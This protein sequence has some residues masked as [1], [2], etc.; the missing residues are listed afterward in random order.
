L[1]FERARIDPASASYSVNRLEKAPDIHVPRV[2]PSVEMSRPAKMNRLSGMPLYEYKCQ[3]CG[4]TFEVLQKFSDPALRVHEKCGGHVE[5]LI[6]TAAL[7]FKGS[8]WY[9]TDYASS[10]GKNQPS[11]DS[12][13][14][15]K[16]ENSSSGHSTP[17]TETKASPT[18]AGTSDKK[19]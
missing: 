13:K 2:D 16:S 7:Q 9:V 17:K 8:G 14:E 12:E 10:N 1:Q 11:K 15:A 4:E 19:V 5:R 3:S 18:P 6:S